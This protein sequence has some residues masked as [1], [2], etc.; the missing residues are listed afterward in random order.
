[1]SSEKRGLLG[2]LEE[3]VLLALPHCGT[4]AYGMKIRRQ[5]LERAGHDVS[6]GAV[7]STLDRMERKGLV[8]SRLADPDPDRGGHPRR[9]FEL[10]ADGRQAV[11]EAARLRRRLWEGLPPSSW[12]T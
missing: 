10:T 6:I 4:D 8:T 5:L 12:T 1:M 9:Y 11:I 7:Y 3:L 2:P